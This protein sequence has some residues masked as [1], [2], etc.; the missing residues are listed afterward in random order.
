[1][2]LFHELRMRFETRSRLRSFTKVARRNAFQPLMQYLPPTLITRTILSSHPAS[3]ICT[4]LYLGTLGITW[5]CVSGLSFTS[6]GEVAPNNRFQG[7]LPLRG[8]GPEPRR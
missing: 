3:T 5:P 2:R 8:S 7:T 4:D 1:M 6:M